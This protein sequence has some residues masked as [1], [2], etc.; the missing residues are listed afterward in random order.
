M[1]EIVN[2]ADVVI[3]T[4]ARLSAL[5]TKKDLAKCYEINVRGTENVLDACLSEGV[6]RLVYMSSIEALHT[7][8]R[9]LVNADDDQPWPLKPFSNYSETKI[10]AEKA[11]IAANGALGSKLRTAIVRPN[12][13]IGERDKLL[14]SMALSK[15]P[16]L[17]VTSEAAVRDVTPVE[18]VV[19]ATL[20]CAHALGKDDCDDDNNGNGTTTTT[21][22]TSDERKKGGGRRRSKKSKAE[23]QA[24][25]IA[26][27]TP[28]NMTMMLEHVGERVGRKPIHIP[29]HLIK[30]AGFVGDMVR[31]VA[32][33]IV[34][35]YLSVMTMKNYD[36]VVWSKGE[37]I[38]K[39][40]GYQP[41]VT[42]DEAISIYVE[43]AKERKSANKKM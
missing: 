43:L 35:D 3:H 10:V 36:S 12:M 41:I 2:G 4:A 17:V 5:D 8:N 27:G 28:M 13:I 20:L 25:N 31:K 1:K 22:T 24:F 21:T 32:A 18:N 40:L 34:P 6:K 9:P 33:G 38:K 30:K 14:V 11:V 42:L 19:H 29:S 26:D 23:G 16:F 7:R 39:V 15:F 37:K